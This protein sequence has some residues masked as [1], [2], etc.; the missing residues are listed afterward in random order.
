MRSRLNRKA[1]HPIRLPRAV[2]GVFVIVAITVLADERTSQAPATPRISDDPVTHAMEGKAIRSLSLED[3]LRLADERNLR[4]QASRSEAGITAGGITAARSEALPHLNLVAQYARLNDV[5]QFGEFSLGQKNNYEVLADVSQVV[6][7]G[8]RVQAALNMAREYDAAITSQIDH[9]RENT[10]FAVH[11]HFNSILLARRFVD[12][13]EEAVALAQKNLSDVRE[14]LAQGMAKRFDLLRAEEQLSS[15]ESDKLAA[16]NNLVKAHLSLL[17]FL[18]LPLD[19]IPVI[20]GTLDI[21]AGPTTAED[22]VAT[23]LKLRSDLAAAERNVAAHR[24][25]LAIARA[26]QRPTVA[27]FGQAKESNPDRSFQDEWEMTW[28]VGVRAELPVFDGFYTRGKTAE[29]RARLQKAELLRDEVAAQVKLD[30]AQAMTDL[31]SA[32]LL[33]KARQ[34]SVIQAEESLRL[35]Q[36][37][38]REGMQQQIDV[39]AAQLALTQSRH[40]HVG[41]LFEKTMAYRRL[42]L[43]MGS[44]TTG[45]DDAPQPENSGPAHQQEQ[46]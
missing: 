45:N 33:V 42:Q 18:D 43:A 16:S 44:M 37:A 20:N 32:R 23:A 4:L 5:P 36:Q 10:A 35:A 19:P 25:A 22:A 14:L 28:M 29:A 8:G 26:G 6:Y 15:S 31:E 17:S 27:L 39:I 2:T 3:A 7:A 30:V 12:V 41:A 9:V 38:Y 24:E 13:A 34:K 11:A 1:P 21:D 40:R 46:R